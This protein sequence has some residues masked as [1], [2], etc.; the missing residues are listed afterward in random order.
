MARMRAHLRRGVQ[1][2]LWQPLL[3]HHVDHLHAVVAKLVVELALSRVGEDRICG[4]NLV[5][6]LARVRILVGMV[7]QRE[8][9]CV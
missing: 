4:S 2:P 6:P 5:E 8:L 7:A 1:D 9:V 3:L